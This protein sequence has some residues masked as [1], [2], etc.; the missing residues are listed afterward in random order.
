MLSLDIRSVETKPELC[1]I[2]DR[3]IGGCEHGSE[4]GLLKEGINRRPSGTQL[5]HLSV[6]TL[7]SPR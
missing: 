1:Q 6:C 5:L 7:V 2:E 4:G 3:S